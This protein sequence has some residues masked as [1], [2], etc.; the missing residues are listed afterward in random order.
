MVYCL[1]EQ[2]WFQFSIN[3]CFE[4]IDSSAVRIVFF[5]FESNWIIG[6]P[7]TVLSWYVFVLVM[8]LSVFDEA[9][10]TAEP[11]GQYERLKAERRS[12]PVYR[13]R[14]SLLQRL[15]QLRGSTAIVIGETGSGK[16]TQIPQVHSVRFRLLQLLLM[17]SVCK[18]KVK[19]GYITVRSKA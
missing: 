19:L 3:V 18:V 12:L 11:S 1:Y 6:A 13:A 2:F 10:E 15:G 16:T 9:A 8:C 5:H 17:W 7:L 14:K 4:Y